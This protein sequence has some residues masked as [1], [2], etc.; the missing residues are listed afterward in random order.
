MPTNLA[1]NP[2]PPQVLGD[3]WVPIVEDPYQLSL[4]EERGYWFQLTQSST[5]VTA[6]VYVGEQSGSPD[7]LTVPAVNIYPAG[8]VNGGGSIRQVVIPC[9]FVSQ[10]AGTPFLGPVGGAAQSP[11]SAVYS[12]TDGTYVQSGVGGSGILDFS[13]GVF[14]FF[15]TLASKRILSVE[16]LHVSARLTGH[17]T[18]MYLEPETSSE[19]MFM[20]FL[21]DDFRSNALGGI[22]PVAAFPLGEYTPFYDTRTTYTTGVGDVY[23]WDYT[24]LLRL[25]WSYTTTPY[26]VAIRADGSSTTGDPFYYAALRVTYCNETRVAVGGR[27]S[28]TVS[29]QYGWGPLGT[30]YSIPLSTPNLIGSGAPALT[31]GDYV[32]TAEYGAFAGFGYNQTSS[33][34]VRALRQ[35]Y[36]LPQPGISG[37]AVPKTK[38]VGTGRE[39]ESSNQI[40]AITL[41]TSSAVLPESHGYGQQISAPVH[42]NAS[43]LQDVVNGAAAGGS[44]YPLARF[45]ARRF[46]ETSSPLGLRDQANPG[47]SAEITVAAFD[48]LPEIADGWKQVDLLFSGSFPT[49][50]TSGTSTWEFFAATPVSAAWQVLGARA[51]AV[52]GL[53]VVEVGPPHWPAPTTYYGTT[54]VAAWDQ[55][56]GSETIDRQG[57]FTLMFASMP[58]VTGLALTQSDMP[59]TGLTECGVMP[60]CIPTG[61]TYNQLTWDASSQGAVGDTFARTETGGWGAADTGQSWTVTD[62]TAADFSVDGTSGLINVGVVNDPHTLISSQTSLN[63][64]VSV[65]VNVDQLASLSTIPIDLIFR[66]VDASNYYYARMV[67][68]VNEDVGIF[69]VK[70]VGGVTTT[71]A[72]LAYQPGLVHSPTTTYV[73]RAQLTGSAFMAKAWEQGTTEPSS[74]TVS[75]VDTSLT[76]VGAVGINVV[77]PTGNTSSVPAV[78]TFTEFTS[79]PSGFGGYELQRS[80]QWSDWATIMLASD[81]TLETFNDFEARIGV[82]SSYRIR[83]CHELDFCGAWSSTVSAT[84]AAPGVTGS[85]CESSVLVFTSNSRQDGTDTLAHIAIW[86]GTPAEQFTF[87]EASGVRMQQMYNRD[88]QIAFHGTERGGQQFERVLLMNNAAVSIANFEQGFQALRDLAWDSIPYVCVRDEHGSRWLA[89][90]IVPNGTYQPPAHSLQFV[91]ITVIEVTATPYP[92]DPA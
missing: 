37:V 2:Y 82:E 18:A 19:H 50:G 62:G 20:D 47:T 30:V 1:Y 89:T 75:A 8:A 65:V 21:G 25:D 59:V 71:I 26:R 11:V 40:P 23:P 85:T 83:A 51:T 72:S 29:P 49:F 57:D 24:A 53:S 79:V 16:F 9:N 3:A 91:S 15:S 70:V 46:G 4:D 12:P 61:V 88:Y 84:I 22:T 67:P 77:V 33:P 87:I 45:Y 7:V 60:Q 41:H 76:A 14:S 68:G 69:L 58:D 44:S 17:T 31:A 73:F 80:D 38:I 92:V 27:R 39:R 64:D 90:V 78:F 48:A 36:E 34:K 81:A 56:S 13:F 86:D 63:A 52:S 54:A 6:R 5:I 32:V 66:Y 43:A 74:W 55:G 10:P 28:A 42:V 35:L